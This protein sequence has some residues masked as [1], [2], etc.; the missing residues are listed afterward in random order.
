MKTVEA[1]IAASKTLIFDGG[2][3]QSEAVRVVPDKSR[4]MPMPDEVVDLL[5]AMRESHP[6]LITWSARIEVGVASIDEEHR[7]LVMLHNRILGCSQSADKT[8]MMGLLGL[9]GEATAAHFSNEDRL[10]TVPHYQHAE[11]HQEEHRSLLREFG[12]QVEDW[13]RG[14]TSA[15]LLCRFMHRWLLQHIVVLDRP[16]AQALRAQRE[17][18]LHEADG[19]STQHSTLSTL[20]LKCTPQ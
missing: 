1:F 20:G 11:E 5:A 10:M 2:F 7:A 12:H 14:I 17:L 9:L 18:S 19:L 13:Y 3:V 6:R 15:E 8:E 4:P 16:L